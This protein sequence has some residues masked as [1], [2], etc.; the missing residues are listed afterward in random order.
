MPDKAPVQRTQ[1]P[2]SQATS[3]LLH[4]ADTEQQSLLSKQQAPGGAFSSS[5]TQ[6]QSHDLGGTLHTRPSP[7]ESGETAEP[8]KPEN[9]Q[10]GGN[11]EH[12]TG[13]ADEEKSLN[14][15]QSFNL[16]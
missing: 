13:G 11:P 16:W 14:W 2:G 1:T 6:Q 4:T 10:Q 8:G 5:T 7:P 3:G 15:V 9:L 12:G